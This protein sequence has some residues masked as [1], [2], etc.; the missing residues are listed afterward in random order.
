VKHWAK[1]T[2]QPN[3]AINLSQEQPA[4][5]RGDVAAIAK[6]ANTVIAGQ[7]LQTQKQPWRHSVDI[8]AHSEP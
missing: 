3:A 4:C 2:Y 7:P 1:P 6:P 8:A 5:V